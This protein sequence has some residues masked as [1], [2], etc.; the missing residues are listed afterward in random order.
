VFIS[1]LPTTVCGRIRLLSPFSKLHL[2]C[3]VFSILA[4]PA[5]ADAHVGFPTD[6]TGCDLDL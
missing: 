2:L 4:I 5:D 6:T 3:C 1:A